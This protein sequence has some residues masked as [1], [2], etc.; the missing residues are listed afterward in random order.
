LF[1]KNSIP[2]LKRMPL[3]HNGSWD[4]KWFW[5]LSCSHTWTTGWYGMVWL[6]LGWWFLPKEWIFAHLILLPTCLDRSRLYT[7]KSWMYWPIIHNLFR[8]RLP[9]MESPGQYRILWTEDGMRWFK[10][11]LL[12]SI[13]SEKCHEGEE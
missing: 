13:T 9:Q 6:P 1:I 5:P 10:S 11:L 2:A 12:T 4:E 3:L 8:K 7:A